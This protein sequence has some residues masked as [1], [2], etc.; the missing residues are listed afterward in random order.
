MSNLYPAFVLTLIEL[1]FI[2]PFIWG[3]K[4]EDDDV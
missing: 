3:K 4:D 2:G 1:L